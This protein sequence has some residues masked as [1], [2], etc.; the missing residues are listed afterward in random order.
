MITEI[1]EWEAFYLIVGTAAGA[2]IGLQ[3]VVL[4]LLAQK[5]LHKGAAD[6]G[7][8]FIAPTIIFFSVSLL[9]SGL[10]MAPWKDFAIPSAILSLIGIFGIIFIGTV[11]RR[12]KKE[13]VYLPQLNDWF[14]RIIL[15][16][17]GFVILVCSSFVSNVHL[18]EMLFGIGGATLLL[19]FVGIHNAWDNVAYMVF[20]QTAEQE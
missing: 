8:V 10:V 18:D 15:P 7:A 20:F 17:I 6:T 3:F 16:L 4:T 5:P 1:A 12:M 9:I 14:Y 19:L 11:A 13:T 2:L